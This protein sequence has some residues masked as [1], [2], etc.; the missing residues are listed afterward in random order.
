MVRI[1]LAV[2]I[3]ALLGGG[4]YVYTRPVVAPTGASLP[5]APAKRVVTDAGC[6]D[7][8][9]I[10]FELTAAA[11]GEPVEGRV[12]RHSAC[13]ADEIEHMSGEID[14]GD[15]TASPIDPGDFRGK[16]KDVLIATRHIYRQ[17]GRF[18]LFARIRAQ[19]HDHGQS[20]RVISCGDGTVQVK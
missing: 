16:D 5:I 19:C 11:A 17:Q 4:L 18:A 6:G 9:S 3:L 10:T 8:R 7:H 13:E 20:T 14:W 12:G 1:A 2:L 15:G